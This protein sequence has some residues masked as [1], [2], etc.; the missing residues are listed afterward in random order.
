MGII[1]SRGSAMASNLETKPG[2]PKYEAFIDTQLSRV[3]TRIR[4]LDAGRSLMI[5][6]TLTLAYFLAMAAFDL[7]VKGADDAHFTGIRLAAFGIYALLMVGFSSQLFLRLY[8]RI[9]PYYAAK[10]LEVN[11]EDAK[12]SVINWL[13]LKG[14][15]LPG[16]I[17]I[18]VGQRAAREL[19][20]ADPDKAVSPKGNWL[21]G[22]ILAGLVLAVLAL[23]LMGP[24]QFPSLLQRAF[25]PFAGSGLG[26]KTEITLLKP[27]KGDVMVPL[28]RRVEFQANIAG[29]FPKFGQPGAPSLLYRY[30]QADPF[31]PLALVEEADGTWNTGMSGDQVQNGF[32][33]KVAAGDAETPEYQVKVQS[34]AQATRFEVT[35][36]YRAYRRLADDRV[37]FPNE[38]A[39]IPRLRD[40]RGTAV[41]L[42]VRTNRELRNAHVE[43]DIDNIK[44]DLQAE[45][46]ADDQKALQV[47]MVL[48][49][50]GTFR[51]LFTSKDGDENTDRSPYQIDVLEDKAPYV[52][53][54]KPGQD[55]SLPP[56]GTLQLEGSAQ[57]DIGIKAMALRLKVLEGDAKPALKPKDYRAG[58]SF[59]FDNGTYPDF[60]DYKD[61]VLL[62]QIKTA[63][64]EPF[65]LKP[66]MVLEYWLEA[67]DS[68]DYPSN[69]GNL[70]MSKSYKVTIEK[71]HDDKK[72]QEER[73][74]T[75]EQQQQHEK[76]QDQKNA[77]ENQKRNQ[78]QGQDKNKSTADEQ[79]SQNFE[80]KLEQARK[81]L[82][83]ENKEKANPKNDDQKSGENKEGN[84]GNNNSEQLP[85]PKKDQ[86]GAEKQNGK[87]GDG[88]QS[89]QTTDQAKKEND[90]KKPS[91]AIGKG[92]DEKT[93]AKTQPD[94]K[95]KGAPEKNEGGVKKSPD[96]K[97][98]PN[99]V[100]EKKEAKTNADPDKKN[101]TQLPEKSGQAN[102]NDN[103]KKKELKKDE[104]DSNIG[105][106][107]ETKKGSDTKP[108]TKIGK[109]DGNDKGPDA[110]SGPGK[111]GDPKLAKD[112]EGAP[113]KQAKG[114]KDGKDETKK[115]ADFGNSG[116]N[117]DSPPGG[118][119]ADDPGNF[120]R[121]TDL[122]LDTLKERMTPEHLKNL[123]W[124]PQEWE[125]F[126]K[127]ARAYEAAIRQKVSAKTANNLKGGNSQI[128]NAPLRPI[129]VN[130]NAQ[131]ESLQSDRALPPPEFRDAQNRFTKG[132][133]DNSTGKK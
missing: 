132:N 119:V 120:K 88:N 122:Q 59:Q 12:N 62:D 118:N 116:P 22:G 57:D 127:D 133:V 48:E 87:K 77:Q 38:Q 73:K 80:K 114:S 2:V 10:Q 93:P 82:D 105:K 90:S 29:R 128:P 124:T 35:Y 5:L 24:N 16:A 112:D 66:G 25:T 111:D 97:F 98:D 91:E 69:E 89:D 20:D 49:K 43:L 109:K 31:V 17:R 106:S 30:Q 13:D 54:T 131:I 34:L 28:G 65:P 72:Q 101:S 92:V 102:A 47:H 8:R 11:I 55:A 23:F 85:P 125:Q 36:H 3:R 52:I 40:F 32:W 39:V 60:L 68:S 45:I 113:T 50:R 96:N 121:G 26:T 33:Y 4:A 18:A 108:D 37:V 67:R 19:K 9:N 7:A 14:R 130:R 15:E 1:L 107:G 21:M 53:L 123:G 99:Q 46:L 6:A 58:K 95:Q 100:K 81:E 115:G 110:K 71:P 129:D 103:V 74:K 83:K 42:I 27:E 86:P 61:F 94:D 51:V 56:N 63:Q 64:G 79:K 44:H 117:G 126:L 70:G 78:G 75:Q 41:T 104:A 84:N 76:E